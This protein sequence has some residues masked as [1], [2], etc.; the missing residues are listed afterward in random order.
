MTHAR[1]PV[2]HADFLDNAVRCGLDLV[3][4]P[5]AP[6]CV[7]EELRCRT[8]CGLDLHNGLLRHKLRFP[9]PELR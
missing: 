4:V 5:S 3:F 8:K 6:G 7:A 1:K 2:P 9:G